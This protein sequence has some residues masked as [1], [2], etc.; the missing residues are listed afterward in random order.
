MP[1]GSSPLFTKPPS[2]SI[3]LSVVYF[4]RHSSVFCLCVGGCKCGVVFTRSSAIIKSR[5]FLAAAQPC[6]PPEQTVSLVDWQAGRLVLRGSCLPSLPLQSGF[7]EHASRQMCLHCDVFFSCRPFFD[8][9][10]AVNCHSILSAGSF[11]RIL[12]AMWL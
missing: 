9:E 7:L 3:S 8:P 5:I 1:T 12:E 2:I 10:H 4:S 11:C 6:N